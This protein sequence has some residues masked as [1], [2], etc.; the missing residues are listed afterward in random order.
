MSD[1]LCSPLSCSSK[2]KARCVLDSFGFHAPQARYRATAQFNSESAP[3]LALPQKESR[4]LFSRATRQALSAVSG[5]W[6]RVPLRVCRV[7]PLTKWS[8]D[9][10]KAKFLEPLHPNEFGC[11]NSAIREFFDPC[12][13]EG[14]MSYGSRNDDGP[15]MKSG[16]DD[17][18]TAEFAAASYP[19]V[20]SRLGGTRLA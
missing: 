14:A 3:N 13:G 20:G 16:V 8:E 7:A 4:D 5:D 19:A 15:N 11:T 10:S 12:L 6:K 9:L 1:W 17:G 2:S 18:R